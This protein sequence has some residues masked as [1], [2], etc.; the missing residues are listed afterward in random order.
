MSSEKN[1]FARPATENEIRAFKSVLT[2]WG[3]VQPGNVE[4][5][6]GEK[7]QVTD[8]RCCRVSNL[9]FD[10]LVEERTRAEVVQTTGRGAT[11]NDP[12][13]KYGVIDAWSLQTPSV[14]IAEFREESW[15]QGLQDTEYYRAC[16]RCREKCTVDCNQCNANREINCTDCGA[17][18]KFDCDGCNAHGRLKC[19][20]CDAKGKLQ[21]ECPVRE[22]DNGYIRCDHC[23]G[24][25]YINGSNNMSYPCRNCNSGKNYCP[26]CK[27]KGHEI[28]DCDH[29]HGA[30]Y[31]DC[32]KC[33]GDKYL[34]CG[35]CDGHRKIECQTCDRQRQ[36]P[37]RD[38]EAKGGRKH[39][40]V[41]NFKSKIHPNNYYLSPFEGGRDKNTVTMTAT[42]NVVAS[43]LTEAHIQGACSEPALQPYA[44]QLMHEVQQSRPTST[45]M[46]KFQILNGSLL[47]M[48]FTYEGTACVAYLDFKNEDVTVAENNTGGLRLD[49]NPLSGKSSGV[50]QGLQDKAKAARDRR[51]AAALKAL[52][53]E[54]RTLG[55][56]TEAGNFKVQADTI[57]AE[58]K[59]ARD[60][61]EKQKTIQ[62]VSSVKNPAFFVVPALTWAA[63]GFVIPLGF[64]HLLAWTG[65]GFFLYKKQK[66][67]LTKLEPQKADMWYLL[68]ILAGV[69]MVMMALSVGISYYESGSQYRSL[70]EKGIGL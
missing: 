12:K 59:R 54:A 43:S 24:S 37:C 13:V 22:C 38:C 14:L 49:N 30:R 5:N 25:G 69:M 42:G 26:N 33:N 28:G 46:E 7:I 68:L 4:K 34:T 32:A 58:D 15:G 60:E 36:M 39:S 27:G 44:L 6:F 48:K 52:A 17:R 8:C 10:I 45:L 51:D 41:I 35:T 50:R 3:S 29:C 53:E 20:R 40:E 64:H 21:Y 19:A 70:F 56:N 1:Y 2:K 65:L 16:S 57:I 47:E 61:N 18:G 66:K 23:S 63:M 9:Q 31:F 67:D 55:F 11:P 62:F